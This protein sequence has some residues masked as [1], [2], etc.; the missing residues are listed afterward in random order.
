VHRNGEVSEIVRAIS[1][2]FI[3]PNVQDSNLEPANLVDTTQRIGTALFYVGDAVRELARA[4]R[5]QQWEVER[6]G[7]E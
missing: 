3:S 1:E 4:T 6:R 2:A 5:E 7:D